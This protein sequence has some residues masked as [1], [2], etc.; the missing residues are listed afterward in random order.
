MKYPMVTVV[1]PCYNSF[2]DMDKCLDAL[3]RQTYKDFEVI[4]VDDCSKDDSKERLSEYA[5]KSALNIKVL[6]NETNRGPGVA[7]NVGIKEAEGQWITF[8]DADDWYTYDRLERM[9][10][11]VVAEGSDC[12]ICNYNRVYLRK[13][14]QKVDFISNIKNP[15]VQQ[16]IIAMPSKSF[17][18]CLIR[19]DIVKSIPIAELYN[20]EDYATL[21]LWLQKCN[22]ISVIKDCL[23]NYYMREGSL[24]RKPRKEAYLNFR[25]A[26]KYMADRSSDDFSEAVEFLGIYYVLYGGVLSAVKAGVK[27]KDVK[28][29][30]SGFINE[31]P[32]WISNQYIN[33]LSKIKRLFLRMVKTKSY[34]GIKLMVVAHSI[35]VRIK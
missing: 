24:S 11:V 23:Y 35:I 25:T 12:V 20:G 27:F 18:T 26:Y 16:D 7:R 14:E 15:S 33:T 29:Y 1:I 17:D 4:I 32:E 34:I 5:A 28:V 2:R 30:I 21:P 13:G 9:L 19:T 8:C 22:K 10:N 3:E 6:S 31:H